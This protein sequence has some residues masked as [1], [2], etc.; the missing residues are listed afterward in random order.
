[1]DY[2]EWAKR[3]IGFSMST[4]AFGRELADRGFKSKKVKRGRGVRGLKLNPAM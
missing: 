1:M 3:E 2:E 4:I